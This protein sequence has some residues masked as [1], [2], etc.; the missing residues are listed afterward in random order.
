MTI[1]LSARSQPP[2]IKNVEFQNGPLPVDK[3]KE[4]FIKVSQQERERKRKREEKKGEEKKKQ[5][6]QKKKKEKEE[7]KKEKK[8][9]NENRRNPTCR[10]IPIAAA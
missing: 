8:E 3:P 2:G 10:R 4:R 9:K 7:N 1:Y 5:K 6:K